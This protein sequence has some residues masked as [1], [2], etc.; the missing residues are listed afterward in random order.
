MAY[1]SEYSEEAV[2]Q[3]EKLDKPAAKRILKKIDSALNNPSHF[4]EQLTGHPEYK[5][6]VG[7][8]RIIANIDDKAC[9]IF[10]RTVGHG[11]NIYD[12]R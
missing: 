11:K 12:E 10:I 8:Y 9:K 1:V 7:N 3:L 6:R 4:F 2:I 5:L